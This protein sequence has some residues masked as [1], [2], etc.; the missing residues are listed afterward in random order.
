[1]S[2]LGHGDTTYD[3][4]VVGGGSGLF[5]AITAAQAGLK[6][7]V[8]EK[9]S[10][11]GGST[12]LSGGGMWLPGNDVAA[13]GGA[14]DAAERVEAY[15]DA[16]VGDT[17]PRA[18]R[19]TYVRHAATV[20]DELDKATPLQFVH[21]RNYADYFSDRVGG[22]ATGRSI[23]PRPFDVN[24]LGSD[25]ALVRRSAMQ[26]PVPMPITGSDYRS[27][28]LMRSLPVQAVPQIVK[29]VAQGIGGKMVGKDMA[30]GGTAL[31]AG[32]IAGARKAGVEMWT[33][34]PL[35][36]LILE[37]GRVTGVI[38]ERND[39][40]VRIGVAGG[41]LLAAGGFD[42]NLELRHKHQSPVLKKGWAFGN[43]ANTGDVLRI[44]Q[45]AGAGTSLLD[46]AWWFP[47]IP[48]AEEG[49]GPS[50]LLAERSLP[51]SM[52]VDA[53][54]HRFFNES[55]DY[56][57]AGKIMLGQ[58]DG[59]APHLPAWLIFDQQYRNSYVFGGG[60]MPGMPL[61]K[62]WYDGG[63][64]HKAAS[65]EELADAIGVPGLPA[66]VQRFNL[67]AAQGNDDD[68]GRGQ[69]HY[70]RYYGDPTNTPNPNL[71]PLRKGPFYAV[72][73]IP[74]DLGTCG[75]VNAD[76]NACVLKED[77]TPIAGLYASGNL[78]AN[79]FGKFYPGPGATIGQGM[80]FAWLAARHVATRVGTQGRKAPVGATSAEASGTGSR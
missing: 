50:V 44:A 19:T 29:R 41:V 59:Q 45:R 34:A 61:P 47:A 80:V 36:D 55:A 3:L 63:V 12:A 8:V 79:V 25:A 77:G 65:I 39:N 62:S 20:A 23:E 38:V 4:I 42:H 9:S 37:D 1:M 14:V 28:N 30:A 10:Y 33:D 76:E 73:V 72:Q 58:D 40:P 35:S 6:V 69:S 17:A 16:V 66:G 54:G 68:F 22:S 64:A 49:A 7:L 71:R 48:P 24:S 60:V 53:T 26:A 32:L 46:Q 11:L 21:M 31:A 18:L 67:L 52:I 78:S 15:L 70:D 74:G 43:P 51:G 2:D 13:R 27:M 57:T 5:G 56:M 75:G